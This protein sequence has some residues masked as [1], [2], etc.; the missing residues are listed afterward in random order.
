[1]QMAELLNIVSGMRERCGEEEN[2]YLEATMRLRDG[3]GM[4]T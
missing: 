2:A 3:G 1:M 4:E